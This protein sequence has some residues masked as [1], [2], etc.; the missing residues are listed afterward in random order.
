[1]DNTS[2][3]DATSTRK[4]TPAEAR[5][6][7]KNERKRA[8]AEAA[9]KAAVVRKRRNAGFGAAFGVIAIVAVIVLISTLGGKPAK[10]STA[11]TNPSAT[12]TS[13]AAP[14]P[15]A[16][17]QAPPSTPPF[18]DVPAGES[19]QLKDKPVVKAGTGTVSKLTVTTLVQGDGPVVKKGDT[20][21]VNYVGVTYK[22][23]A[24]FDSSW[25]RS[26]DFS[27][28]I[29]EGAVIPGWD[30]G[31]VGIKVGSRVQLDIPAALA[32]GEKA[33]SGPS[34][35]LRFVVDVLAIVPAG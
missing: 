11:S 7:A 6:A 21:R 23:G 2:L 5:R 10:K 32:Y 19:A 30:Q 18:P 16:G 3:K 15:T 24:E 35:D 14:A 22:D 12:A 27:T 29:G 26:Q 28:A 31:L 17:P 34:G 33:T 13:S 4:P 9:R 1:V 8:G 20:I 25:K